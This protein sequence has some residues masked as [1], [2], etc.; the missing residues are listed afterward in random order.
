M[1]KVGIGILAVL[2]VLAV[3]VVTAGSI[4]PQPQAQA[5]AANNARAREYAIIGRGEA[6]EHVAA[7]RRARSR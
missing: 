6:I 1:T 2:A 5:G 3:L 4:S 7:Q